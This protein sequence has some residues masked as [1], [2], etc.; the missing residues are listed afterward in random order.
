M[1][2]PIR[3]LFIISLFIFAGC[4]GSK[5][6]RPDKKYSAAELHEDFS[7]MR[8]ALERFHPSLYWY[9]SKDSMDQYFAHYDAAIQDSMTEHDFGFRIVA[10]V[11]TAIRCGHTSFNFSKRYTKFM[12][13]KRLPAFPLGLKVW[14]DTMV[15]TFNMNRRDSIIKRGTLVTG[16]NLWENKR[17][18]DTLFNYMSADGYSQNVN[19]IRL[20]G[21]FSYYHRNIIGLSKMYAVQYIDSTG[22]Q[23][24]A[25]LPLFIPGADSVQVR[26]AGT[27]PPSQPRQREPKSSRLE[28]KRSFRIDTA[29]QV[30]IM[31]INTFASGSRLP[32]FYKKSFKWLR[33]NKTPNLII[34]VRNNGGGDINHFAQLSRYVRDSSF[35]VADTAVAIQ[36]HFGKYGKYIQ[37]HFFNW[38]AFFLLT[39]KYDDGRHHFRYWENHEYKPKKKNHYNGNVY[40]IISGPTFSAT[41]LFAQSVKGQPNVKLVGEEAG[42]GAHG[43]NGVMIPNLTLPNSHLR[44]RLPL[45]RI[46]QYNH[47]PKDGHGVLPDI[48]VPPTVEGVKRGADLKMEKVMELIKGSR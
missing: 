19:Y 34:D 8:Q 32:S 30:A 27:P 43:N 35:R 20:S 31:T 36:N 28:N 38:I 45:F 33:K 11:L 22:Q 47:P 10:P 18:I 44:V 40:V 16:I 1:N 7:I 46:V 24:L 9:T 29:R 37:Y 4:A 6:F 2:P 26:P 12:E 41:T 23:K 3:I 25:A 42:G 48:E 21:S 14:K 5:S 17:V 13:D 15:V 39:S